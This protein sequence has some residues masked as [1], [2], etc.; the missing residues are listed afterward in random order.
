MVKWILENKEWVFSGIGV[1]ILG[2]LIVGF[3]KLVVKKKPSVN[4]Q[5]NQAI[6]SDT[7]NKKIKTIE[8]EQQKIRKDLTPE[9]IVNAVKSVPPLQRKDIVKHY[10]G[11]RVKWSGTLSSVMDIFG[12]DVLMTLRS[13]DANPVDIVFSVNPANYKGLSLIN[14]GHTI[15][16]EGDIS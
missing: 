6:K 5:S 2:F 7:D 11:I 12:P 8:S 13:S 10:Q 1:F 16:I 15:T 3:R 4:T 14:I 9:A